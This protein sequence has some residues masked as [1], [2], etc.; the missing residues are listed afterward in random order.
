MVCPGGRVV[1]VREVGFDP[2]FDSDRESGILG[3]VCIASSVEWI[4]ESCFWQCESLSVVTFAT[5][6]YQ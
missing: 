6:I 3:S 4:R 1:H 2:G 5:I